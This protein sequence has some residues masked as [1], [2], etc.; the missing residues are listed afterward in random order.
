MLVS[1][2][3]CHLLGATSF[4]PAFS[5]PLPAYSLSL[6]LSRPSSP[7]FTLRSLFRTPSDSRKAPLRGKSF[8]ESTLLSKARQA[9]VLLFTRAVVLG[10]AGKPSSSLFLRLPLTPS[11]PVSR[12]ATLVAR[13]ARKI[14][15]GRGRLAP[16]A[17]PGDF[18]SLKDRRS[19]SVEQPVKCL[20]CRRNVNSSLW[21]WRIKVEIGRAHV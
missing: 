9:R 8:F 3:N 14:A 5:L 16:L 11:C 17:S 19:I 2:G 7:R 18:Y 20:I 13:V 21:T 1:A 12:A 4:L 10:P 6:S 15:C